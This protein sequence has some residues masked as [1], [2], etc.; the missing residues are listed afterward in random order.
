V[1]ADCGDGGASAG[2]QKEVSEW[3]KEGAGQAQQ[4]RVEMAMESFGAD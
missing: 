3:G 1:N 4:N 2:A